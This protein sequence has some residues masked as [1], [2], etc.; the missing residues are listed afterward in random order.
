M[1]SQPS[2]PDSR[3]PSCSRRRGYS[4]VATRRGRLA[5]AGSP[6][7]GPGAGAVASVIGTVVM[8]RAPRAMPGE[9]CSSLLRPSAQAPRR[10]VQA[11][12]QSS[13]V[14]QVVA[15][16]VSAQSACGVVQYQILS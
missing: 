6:E 3:M 16:S 4:H 11:S 5:R 9:P 12:T 14:L 8:G 15:L 2:G 7:S 10:V 13:W 1:A